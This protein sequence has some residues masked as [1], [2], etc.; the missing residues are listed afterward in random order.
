[1]ESLRRDKKKTLTI[2]LPRRQDWH[3]HA[4]TDEQRNMLTLQAYTV[5]AHRYQLWLSIEALTRLDNAIR[6]RRCGKWCWSRRG[7][8]IA[9]VVSPTLLS[10]REL[11]SRSPLVLLTLSSCSLQLFSFEI[12]FHQVWGVSIFLCFLRQSFMLLLNWIKVD[13][14][15]RK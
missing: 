14:S 8:R 10:W 1:M 12:D 15:K 3:V 5:I 2:R 7:K 4:S 13:H 11:S 6:S 9:P